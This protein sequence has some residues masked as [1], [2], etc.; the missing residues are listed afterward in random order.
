VGLSKFYP[1]RLK[2]KLIYLGIVWVSRAIWKL[3]VEHDVVYAAS[4]PWTI[5]THFGDIDSVHHTPH[6]GVDFAVPEG[7][8]IHSVTDGT[9]EVVRDEGN[10]SFGRSVRVRTPDGKLVIYGHL[11][12]WTVQQGTHI[13]FGDVL[14]HSGNTGHS[15]GP[16]LHFQ[17]NINGTPVNPEPTIMEGVMRKAGDKYVY[18]P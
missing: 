18:K 1:K 12:D 13:H 2:G 9:V 10:V 15:T 5:T 3:L 7:T 14:G 16:H 6:K 8:P 17:V 11:H 4:L